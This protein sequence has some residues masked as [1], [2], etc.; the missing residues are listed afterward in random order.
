M[1]KVKLVEYFEFIFL[2]NVEVV[3]NDSKS[4]RDPR[5]VRI[6]AN[7]VVSSLPGLNSARECR[8]LW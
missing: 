3:D 5:R 7:Q 2:P 4:A 8:S 1:W 6:L